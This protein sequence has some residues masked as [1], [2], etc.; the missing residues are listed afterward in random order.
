[1]K[2][3]IFSS[4][5]FQKSYSSKPLIRTKG[6]RSSRKQLEDQ[7]YDNYLKKIRDD[8]RKAWMKEKEER[9]QASIE[10]FKQHREKIINYRLRKREVSLHNL[11][12]HNEIMDSYNE[13]RAR[14]KR[15]RN[16]NRINQELLASQDRIYQL[17]K[18]VKESKNY[19]TPDNIDKQLEKQFHPGRVI[20]PTLFS[21]R[22]GILD[23]VKHYK[24]EV[25]GEHLNDPLP[26]YS[27]IIRKMSDFWDVKDTVFIPLTENEIKFKEEKMKGQGKTHKEE[28]TVSTYHNFYLENL[29]ILRKNAPEHIQDFEPSQ[30]IQ[31]LKKKNNFLDEDE[32]DE[33]LPE[34]RLI[35]EILDDEEVEEISEETFQSIE[36]EVEIEEP[37]ITDEDLENIPELQG[38]DQNEMDDFMNKKVPLEEYFSEMP[39]E[40]EDESIEDEL[41]T[42][43]DL[44]EFEIE[45]LEGKENGK[46]KDK[47]GKPPK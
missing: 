27:P 24:L 44:D 35:F 45:K 47:K 14:Q 28:V 19:L 41:D 25:T 40:D 12:R 18:M 22:I 38:Y 15:E 9:N 21:D 10:K 29:K 37:E 31:T 7:A 1:M 32:E 13:E 39:D 5:K 8:Y 43:F 2:R 20:T 23:P 46:N 42:S 33:I 6:D 17:Q 4:L 26:H 30:E 3:I 34:E 36:D 11:K 16:Q